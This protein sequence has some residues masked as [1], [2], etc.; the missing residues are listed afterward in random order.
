MSGGGIDTVGLVAI[1]GI[2]V[3]CMRVVESGDVVG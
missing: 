2:P 1:C 3:V